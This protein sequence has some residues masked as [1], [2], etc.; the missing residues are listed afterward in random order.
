MKYFVMIYSLDHCRSTILDLYLGKMLGFTSL[1]EA[2]R[3]VFPIGGERTALSKE[4]CGCGSSFDDCELWSVASKDF[5][6]FVSDS[7]VCGFI[8]SSKN[9]KHF[10]SCKSEILNR[11]FVEI[12][13]YRSF[14]NWYRSVRDSLD[15]EDRVSFSSVHSDRAFLASSLR[16]YLRKYSGFAY[17]EYVLT[18]LRLM[19][20]CSRPVVIGD[21]NDVFDF[22]GEY[23]SRVS[24]HDGSN[25]I[26]RG[27]RIRHLT[28]IDLLHFSEKDAFFNLL[29]FIAKMKR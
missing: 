7:D 26:F 9:I 22:V 29:G 8:D 24:R 13:L 6:S 4:V 28:E 11:V 16:L 14:G 25:H 2:K 21:S 15:R 23:S 27:N 10:A 5:Y 18:Y 17:L 3:T 20:A 1:G 12:V 19:F